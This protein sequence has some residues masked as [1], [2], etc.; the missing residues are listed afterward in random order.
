MSLTRTSTRL[1]AALAETGGPGEA[2]R[3]A[4][5][6]F[7]GAEAKN[8]PLADLETGERVFASE[9]ARGALDKHTLA[10]LEVMT[11]TNGLHALLASKTRTAYGS[12]RFETLLSRPFLDPG[13]IRKRQAA[14]RELTENPALHARVKAAF[15]ALGEGAD[16]RARERFFNFK[17]AAPIFLIGAL[18]GAVALYS[19]GV[20]ALAAVTAGSWMP[21]LALGR[22]VIVWMLVSGN[23]IQSIQET[24]ARLLEYKAVVK[25]TASLAGPLSR[26][27][28]EALRELGS[29]FTAGKGRLGVTAGL[30]SRLM[31]GGAALLPDFLYLHSAL[32]LWP[33][34]LGVARRRSEFAR[35]FGAL[36]ELDVYQALAETSHAHADWSLYPEIVE[37]AQ[38]RLTISEGHHPYLVTHGRSVGNDARLEPGANFQLLTG[39]N[40]GGKSTFLKMTALLALLAQI[41]APVP[42]R[43]M[44]L[45]PLELLT[46]IEI[47]HDLVG[48]KSLYDAETDRIL[49]VI[50]RAE[51]GTRLFV[52]IDEILQGTNPQDRAAIERAIVRYLA[53]TGRLF[54]VATHNLDVVTLE[55]AEPGVRNSHVEESSDGH[56]T[57][58][59]L[60]GPSAT[61][62]AVETL[63]RKGFPSDIVRDSRR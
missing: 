22:Y 31:P 5:A 52:I 51:A 4:S 39:V 35:L 17:I 24:R 26:S 14:A 7:D 15:D 61:R 54:L 60:P 25:L 8:D 42:A 41:G 32:T 58:K 13:E 56:A 34:A 40:M 38:P 1:A 11:P 45:T 49:E 2:P 43:A 62:N 9:P 50:H 3:A 57:H 19:V 48:G 47:K 53:R 55:G 27:R 16:R 46:S 37:D 21:V 20:A 28:S 30:L 18:L 44:T 33:V 59:V 29:E 10:D 36:S 6:A 23:L 12:R 63:E